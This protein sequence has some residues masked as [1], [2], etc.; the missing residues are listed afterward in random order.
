MRT[1]PSPFGY[2]LFVALET[3]DGLRLEP[4][5]NRADLSNTLT[6]FGKIHKG[7]FK[8]EVQHPGFQ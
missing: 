3:V 7:G 4:F 2:R 6:H 8:S 5:V 1:L